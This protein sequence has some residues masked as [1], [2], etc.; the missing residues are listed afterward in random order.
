MYQNIF[1]FLGYS[2]CGLW[3]EIT[4]ISGYNWIICFL[5]H[6]RRKVR[7]NWRVRSARISQAETRCQTVCR[8]AGAAPG[9][10]CR[11][12]YMRPLFYSLWTFCREKKEKLSSCL[13]IILTLS[14]PNCR[15]YLKR[16]KK[17]TIISSVVTVASVSEHVALNHSCQKGRSWAPC[18]LLSQHVWGQHLGKV[19]LYLNW[20]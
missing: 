12:N 9:G 7:A 11:W 2:H 14:V 8:W 19:W 1:F 5:K 18:G 17:F 3:Y 16:W 20:K 15:L 10:P 6:P 4:L 13:N